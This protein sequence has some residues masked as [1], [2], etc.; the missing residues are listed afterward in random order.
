MSMTQEK[1]FPTT[2]GKLTT[3]LTMLHNHDLGEKVG[4]KLLNNG[5]RFTV[6]KVG[7]MDIAKIV[8]AIETAAKTNHIIDS[9][10]YREI[11]SLYHAILE[12][13]QGVC[14]GPTQIGEI[15]RTVGLTFAVVRGPLSFQEEGDWICVCMYG[16]IGAPK[17]GFEHEVLGFSINHL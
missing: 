8:G 5:Y 13:S 17:K 6:G 14:R 9:K 7:A 1:G 15:L 2:I 12:A 3:L 16:T 4:Q 10:Q 11:H